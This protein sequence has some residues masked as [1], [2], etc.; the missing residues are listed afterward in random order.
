MG[1]WDCFCALCG[2]RLS[3]CVQFKS[4]PTQTAEQDNNDDG[5]DSGASGN[6]PF[7]TETHAYDPDVLAEKDVEWLSTCRLLGK[8]VEDDFNKA[9][10]TRRGYYGDH[11]SFGIFGD[12]AERQSEELDPNDP[13][14]YSHACYQE[15]IHETVGY[16]FHEKCWEII[17]KLVLGYKSI[18]EIDKAAMYSAMED[19]TLSDRS[20]QLSY[21]LMHGQSQY[22][23]C[24]PGEEATVCDPGLNILTSG[25]IMSALPTGPPK[26]LTLSEKI[27]QD[28]FSQ[29]PFDVIHIIL[30]K[31]LGPSRLKLLTASHHVYQQSCSDSFWKWMMRTDIVPWCPELHS[32]LNDPEFVSPRVDLKRA[33]LYMKYATNARANRPGPFMGLANRRRI[34]A[35]CKPLAELY[36]DILEQDS[37]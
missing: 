37:D 27:V 2:A 33:Y 21:G 23:N 16:P 4:R 31:L 11:G 14:F 1:S 18:N 26:Y 3:S 30:A 17:S 22:W 12:R 25:D 8:L 13:G 32:L 7:S 35:A 15:T 10:I 29:L 5:Q 28:P 24:Y 36:Q 20:L 19:F 34:I 6:D 9:F